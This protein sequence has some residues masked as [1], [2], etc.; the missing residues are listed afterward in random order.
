MRY[1]SILILAC[2][3]CTPVPAVAIELE[4]DKVITTPEERHILTQCHRLGG[5]YVVTQ[6]QLAMAFEAVQQQ[7]IEI[8]AQRAAELV[9]EAKQSCR[10]SGT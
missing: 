5:C 9:H 8:A 7:T 10:R 4:G 1:L 2:V 3:S 6:A